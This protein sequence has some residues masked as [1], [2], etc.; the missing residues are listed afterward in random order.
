MKTESKIIAVVLSCFG[1]FLIGTYTEMKE[2]FGI[3]W[4]SEQ[5]S[6]LGAMLA[7]IATIAAAGAAIYAAV[8]WQHQIHYK[9]QYS[10]IKAFKGDYIGWASSVANLSMHIQL[11]YH[12][13]LSQYTKPYYLCSKRDR[14]LL[15]LIEDYHQSW[16]DVNKSLMMLEASDCEKCDIAGEI[17]LI[18][19]YFEA[20]LYVLEE[21]SRCEEHM[22]N[23]P[24]NQLVNEYRN[25]AGTMEQVHIRCF[26]YLDAAKIKF[27]E[28]NKS[29]INTH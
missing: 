1:A 2:G 12:Y 25:G 14:V 13:K 20:F 24:C 17:Q 29:S 6:A 10:A 18:N 28:W 5:F 11:R 22:F 27:D 23:P 3:S 7:G 16:R 8:K 9:E 21:L 4:E 26:R 19:D 15:R